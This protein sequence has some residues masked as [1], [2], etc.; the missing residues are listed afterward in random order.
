MFSL[1]RGGGA[2][3]ALD[4][5]REHVRDYCFET[6]FLKTNKDCAKPRYSRATHFSHDADARRCRASSH[7]T[8][9]TDRSMVSRER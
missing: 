1:A 6:I 8:G 3:R 9:S 7:A 5:P 2:T 4:G